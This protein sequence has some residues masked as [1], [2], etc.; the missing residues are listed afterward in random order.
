[1]GIWI[2]GLRWTVETKNDVLT[3][4]KLREKPAAAGA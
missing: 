4:L 3:L 1:M 2:G